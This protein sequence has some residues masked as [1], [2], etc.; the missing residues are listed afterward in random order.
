MDTAP[1]DLISHQPAP[2]KKMETISFL[3]DKILSMMVSS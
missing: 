2:T 1:N 3:D